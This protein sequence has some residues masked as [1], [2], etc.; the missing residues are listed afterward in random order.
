M[1]YKGCP[2]TVEGYLLCDQDK[3]SGKRNSWWIDETDENG[4]K[5]WLK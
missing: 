5:T 1:Q 2:K 3:I 4:H